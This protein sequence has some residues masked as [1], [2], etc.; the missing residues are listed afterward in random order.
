MNA[1]EVERVEGPTL[2]MKQNAK[3]GPPKL[4]RSIRV[5]HPRSSNQPGRKFVQIYRVVLLGQKSRYRQSRC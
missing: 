3:G 2:C 1:V 4:A 5:C